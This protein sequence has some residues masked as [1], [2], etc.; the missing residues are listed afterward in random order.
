MN[1]YR[2]IYHFLPE[3]NW[4][5]D[6]NGV[7]FYK[8]EY[9]LFYQYNPNGYSWGTI[10]W[11][12][13]KSKDLVHWEHMPIALY[14]SEDKGEL[15]C[16]SGCAV[17]N[18]DEPTIFYTSIG[19]GKRHQS[20]GAEQWMA[21]SKDDMVTWE[22]YDDNPVLTLDIHG[23]IE[24][25]EWRD[26]FVWKEDESWFMVVGG[27]HNKK[28]CALIY[29]SADLKNWEFLNILAEE[30]KD[31]IWECP[32]CFKLGDKYV[33]VYSPNEQV[34][35]RIGT[36]NKDY[37]FVTEYV[38]TLDYSGW[39]GFYAPNSLSDSSG[40][41]IMWGWLTDV[42]RGE[43]NQCGEWSGVQ[44]LPRILEIENNML[45]MKPVKE[46]EALRTNHKRYENVEITE[47][48]LPDAKGK[49]LEVIAEI[50]TIDQLTSF[51]IDVLASENGEEKTSIIYDSDKNSFS[52][53]RKKSSLSGLCHDSE[54]SGKII[55]DKDENLKLHI[56]VDHSTIEVFANYKETI[57]TRV[58]PVREDSENIVFNLI[59]GKLLKVKSLD[60]WEMKSIWE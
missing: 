17:I 39:E 2:P 12:H 47:S 30:E 29:R 14:P 48:W 40:R 19:E 6:P 10:H 11:G 16:F 18:G 35:Y 54:L 50:E 46:L 13:A 32:N 21:I 3:K 33:L 52:V 20:T 15:H 53:N 38:S 45:Y 26:P 4:M 60:I 1:L 42:A 44:S 7:V 49:A 51:S 55:L 25:K 9:H 37:K 8:G 41:R 22:K 23:G 36:I 27:S 24:I 58:Y 34:Q 5:N 28:G 57:S 59:K 56:F 31:E 43:F